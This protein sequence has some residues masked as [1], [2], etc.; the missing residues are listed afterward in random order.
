MAQTLL[1]NET[2]PV[3]GEAV[4]QPFDLEEFIRQHAQRLG[5]DPSIALKMAIQESGLNPKATS[6]VG[7][8]GVM[9]IMP[10]TWEGIRKAHPELRLTDP[11]DAQ[12]N[13]KAG[14]TFFADL[15]KQYNG[16][17]R[18]ALAAYNGGGRAVEALREGRPFGE[19]QAYLNAILGPTKGPVGKAMGGPVEFVGQAIDVIKRGVGDFLGDQ[20]QNLFVNPTTGKPRSVWEVAGEVAG[21]PLAPIGRAL[22]TTAVPTNIAAELLGIGGL[23][24]HGITQFGG[25]TLDPTE[26]FVMQAWP[27]GEAA[28]AKVID[29]AMR[30]PAEFFSTLDELNRMGKEAYQKAMEKDFGGSLLLFMPAEALNPINYLGFGVF[31]RVPVL[32]A[33]EQLF[34]RA[35][36]EVTLGATSSIR[37]ALS[38]L[39]AFK[40]APESIYRRTPL[41]VKEAIVALDRTVAD[42]GLTLDDALLRLAQGDETVIKMLPERMAEQ[43]QTLSELQGVFQMASQPYRRAVEHFPEGIKSGLA[44]YLAY[45]AFRGKS[46]AEI[47]DE[48]AYHLQ[49]VRAQRLG[50]A[51]RRIDVRGFDLQNVFRPWR[52]YWVS[53]VLG[54][55]VYLV[56]TFMDVLAR[57]VMVGVWPFR[58]VSNLAAR[59]KHVPRIAGAV[60]NWAGLFKGEIG[61]GTLTTTGAGIHGPLAVNVTEQAGRALVRGLLSWLGEPRATAVA[62]KAGQFV[63]I[64]LPAVWTK[65]VRAT[66]GMMDQSHFIALFDAGYQ[67]ALSAA[68]REVVK[69]AQRQIARQ[70]Q[71]VAR[72][73]MEPDPRLPY[74]VH[75][76]F[77]RQISPLVARGD[78]EGIIAAA[79]A[80]DKDALFLEQLVQPGEG[81]AKYIPQS[82]IEEMRGPLEKAIIAKDQRAID[83]IFRNAHLARLPAHILNFVRFAEGERR[84]ILAKIAAKGTLPK[85]LQRYIKK[86]ID[87]TPTPTDIADEVTRQKLRDEATLPMRAVADADALAFQ[88]RID[89]NRMAEQSAR[90]EAAVQVA[91]AVE[92]QPERAEELIGAL[93]ETSDSIDA[94]NQAT[95]QVLDDFRANVWAVSDGLK[96]KGADAAKLWAD[97][98]SAFPELTEYLVGKEP[99][100]GLLWANY[101]A[102][103]SQV[104]NRRAAEAIMLWTDV[105][106][107]AVDVPLKTAAESE[108]NR[109]A[110]LSAMRLARKFAR[111]AAIL[112]TKGGAANIKRA[113][114]LENQVRSI[115]MP[116]AE[117]SVEAFARLR[118]PQGAIVADELKFTPTMTEVNMGA[119]AALKEWQGYIFRS[120]RDPQVA[121]SVS[122]ASKAL[123]EKVSTIVGALRKASAREKALLREADA[124][125][126]EQ[127]FNAAFG[128][129]FD[130]LSTPNWMAKMAAIF[131]FIRF[132]ANA[133][134][135]WAGYAATRPGA[136]R[137]VKEVAFPEGG[138]EEQTGLLRLTGAHAL[139]VPG[140]FWKPGS[141]LSGLPLLQGLILRDNAP[142]FQQFLDILNNLGL[143]PGPE[144]YGLIMA[145][146]GIA[147]QVV[148]DEKGNPVDI[149]DT[150]AMRII[151]AVDYLRVVSGAAGAGGGRGVVLGAEPRY[152]LRRVEEELAAMQERGVKYA[153]PRLVNADYATL[154]PEEKAVLQQARQN[155]NQRELSRYAL[156]GSVYVPPELQERGRK[157]KDVLARNGI[158]LEQWY[159]PDF[160]SSLRRDFR[161][162][163][164]EEVGAEAFSRVTGFA[165]TEAERQA[166][167]REQEAFRQWENQVY[168]PQGEVLKPLLLAIKQGDPTTIRQRWNEYRAAVFQRYSALVEPVI[169]E[170]ENAHPDDVFLDRFRELTDPQRFILPDGSIDWRKRDE[171]AEGLLRNQPQ[172]R[173]E[174]VARET[175]PRLDRLAEHAP[176]AVATIRELLD[177]KKQV[178]EYNKIPPYVGVSEQDTLR[179]TT[180]I[181]M[182]S[183]IADRIGSDDAARSAVSRLAPNWY[184]SYEEAQAKENPER[185]AYRRAHPLMSKWYG[186]SLSL[187]SIGALHPDAQVIVKRILD[188]WRAF[189]EKDLANRYFGIA[190]QVREAAMRQFPVL[191]EIDAVLWAE[192]HGDVNL[193]NELKQRRVS[194]TLADGRVVENV[195]RIY[196]QLEEQTR[197]RQLAVQLTNPDVD[198][199]LFLFYPRSS[200]IK[201]VVR[202]LVGDDPYDN[203]SVYDT[204]KRKGTLATL[205]QL[206]GIQIKAAA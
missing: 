27:E 71:A 129:A 182:I 146:G 103:R 154:K 47:A 161:R 149:L 139:P 7:A 62:E 45:E 127:G 89:V 145:A 92:K 35:G 74:D 133:I 50:E 98:I 202:W 130:Y 106:K 4:A 109:Q 53:Q 43:R 173:R 76:R 110:L 94:L 101:F 185:A 172:A 24:R 181:D 169:R 25:F 204:A 3:L 6:Y 200:R 115:F 66:A 44:E 12:Q 93:L 77:M 38:K 59:Y 114:S 84:A 52:S 39:E 183:V 113:Q 108:L 150:D 123:G 170:R 70:V 10:A 17:Y 166:F 117:D 18:L 112:R 87:V 60:S 141:R 180:V 63:P 179:A 22:E 48:L 201:D 143:F 193:Y 29:A 88:A 23:A 203:V 134:R 37:K 122:E 124:F 126:Q 153:D 90:Q 189:K 118:G 51:A 19:T 120:M 174:Y 138:P 136:F 9:Q 144:A 156:P 26:G 85:E 178:E 188:T 21:A 176:Q 15:L 196:D 68:M 65:A 69:P 8:Q 58:R 64:G 128:T 11:F 111:E 184:R 86:L 31:R 194:V 131:P 34:M 14:L 54:T 16:D 78:I 160:R 159:D 40:E 72:A 28:R 135:W 42:L 158:T 163:I 168:D 147:E 104:H 41:M 61:V 91:A 13:V 205:E 99:N 140:W 57:S 165:M 1:P 2:V 198:L 186:S 187:A 79:R 102:Q 206:L 36:E 32:G 33:A 132:Q 73:M 55:P 105:M 107:Q 148:R 100:R 155:V 192:A 83:E 119:H 30:G 199:M 195:N 152:I 80:V 151:P 125:A 81:I 157:L 167:H 82:L 164:G 5:I 20:A 67:G 162:Q 96:K 142:A 171:V 197:A 49:N 121:T 95:F 137:I 46:A 175:E 191:K 116:P 177:A 190:D 75:E 97:H 56:N